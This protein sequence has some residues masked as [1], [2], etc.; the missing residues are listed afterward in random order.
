M[1]R[2]VYSVEPNFPATDQHPQ[3][4]RFFVAG[5]SIIAEAVHRASEREAVR[6]ARLTVF[7]TADEEAIAL[8][9]KNNPDG[10]A[11]LKKALLAAIEQMLPQTE[12]VVDAIGIPSLAEIDAVRN[13][14]PPP[15]PTAEQKLAASGLTVAELRGLLGLNA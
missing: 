11:E 3:A 12:C 7:G 4:Q 5:G 13:P 15:A 6:A 2:C 1:I 14:S 9:L 8:A 10:R